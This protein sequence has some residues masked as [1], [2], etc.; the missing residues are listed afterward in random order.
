MPK[1]YPNKSLIKTTGKEEI[2]HKLLREK[3]NLPHS[4]IGLP[5]AFYNQSE[6]KSLISSANHIIS[7]AN[8]IIISA[9]HINT[10]AD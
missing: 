9:N 4:K 2:S 3:S 1:T 10:T 8:Y 7:S 6:E 5:L